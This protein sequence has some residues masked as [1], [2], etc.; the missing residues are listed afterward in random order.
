MSLL[1][2]LGEEGDPVEIPALS[3]LDVDVLSRRLIRLELQDEVVI[4]DDYFDT[5]NYAVNVFSGVGPVEIVR[6]IPFQ[7][8]SKVTRE[9]IIETQPMTYGT[10]YEVNITS[11]TNRAG[12]SLSVSGL[13]FDSRYTKGDSI[14]RSIPKHYD[15]RSTSN[16]AWVMLAIGR[17]D[18][19]IGGS[20]DDDF[21]F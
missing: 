5:S 6:I 12:Q 8:G 13:K 19:L 11:A 21:T 16:L 14:L 9:I 15:K 1:I 20:R 10:T 2:L 17:Q 7:N 18:D 4:N 3:L